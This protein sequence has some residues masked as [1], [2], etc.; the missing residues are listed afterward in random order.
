MLTVY[1][2]RQVPNV[3]SAGDFLTA[4]FQ[5]V[6]G[7]RTELTLQQ[8]RKDS[9][10]SG[11]SELAPVADRNGDQLLSLVE[12]QSYNRNVASQLLSFYFCPS[13]PFKKYSDDPLYVTKVGFSQFAIR[14]YVALGAKTVVGLSGSVPAEGMMYPGSKTRLAE[15]T[16]GTSNTVSV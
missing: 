9:V 5:N 8:I 1:T 3:K 15:C 7:N 6:L 11:H 16:D 12:L 4:Q 10:L 13:Y 2:R 14:N